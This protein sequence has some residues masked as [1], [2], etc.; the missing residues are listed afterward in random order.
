MWGYFLDGF[1]SPDPSVNIITK[2]PSTGLGSLEESW[3]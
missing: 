3:Q 1:G 2:D